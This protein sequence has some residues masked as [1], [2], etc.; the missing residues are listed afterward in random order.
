MR[1][2]RRAAGV[3]LTLVT[4]GALA[5]VSAPPAAAASWTL[6]DLD[7]RLCARPDQGRPWGYFGVGI[8]GYWDTE[9]HA[10]LRNLPPGT[11]S[12]PSTIYPDDWD[13]RD[14]EYIGMVPLSIGPGP[15]GDWTAE[16]W[17]SDGEEEQT[18]PVVIEFVEGCN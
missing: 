5:L 1:S 2:I 16:L 15:A 12:G 11:T 4:F 6:L 17:A 3:L 13:P 7:Q 14:H 9:I 10:G 18:V 8:N